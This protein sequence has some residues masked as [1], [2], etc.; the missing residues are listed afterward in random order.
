ML[1]WDRAALAAASQY[2]RR[3][4]SNVMRALTRAGDTSGWIVHGLMLFALL[5]VDER[6]LAVMV[7]AGVLATVFSQIFKRVF[8]RVRPGAAIAG[9]T[10]REANPDPFSFPSGH[11]T[12]A[13]AIATSA[14]AVHPVLGG[15]ETALATAIACSRI[16]LGS[17]FPV[18]VLGGVVLGVVCGLVAWFVLL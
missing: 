18:D 2:E 16:Y 1:R 11:S 15:V 12:V 3:A 10:V 8:R 7:L 5:R 4:L 9:F 13:F 17:H 6:V 14:A